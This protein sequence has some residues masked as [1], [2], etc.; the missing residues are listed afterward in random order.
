M[1]PLLQIV[2]ILQLFLNIFS[3]TNIYGPRRAISELNSTYTSMFTLP[4]YAAKESKIAVRKFC[5]EV[6]T[7]GVRESSRNKVLKFDLKLNV[8][9]NIYNII[10]Y[11]ISHTLSKL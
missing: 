5:R 3:K 2:E 8:F 10:Q 11:N 7:A 1:S 9:C 6:R 4:L